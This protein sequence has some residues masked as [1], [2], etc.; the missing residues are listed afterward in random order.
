MRVGILDKLAGWKLPATKAAPSAEVGIRSPFVEGALTKVVVRDLYGLDT[1]PTTRAEAMSVPA[2]A[3]GRHLIVNDVSRCPLEV[4]APEDVELAP[5]AGAWLQSTRLQTSTQMRAVWTAD[6]H[7]FYGWSLW[8][9]SRA[10]DGTILDGARCP[11]EWWELDDNGTVLV[12][13]Q[14]VSSEQVILIPGYHEG[15]LSS[16][17]ETIR[18]GRRLEDLALDRI[19]NPVPAVELH[20]TSPVDLDPDEVRTLVADWKSAIRDEDGAVAYTPSSVEVKIHGEGSSDLLIQG[21]NAAAV[22]AAR[23]VGVPAAM[24]DA[25]NVNSSLTYETLQGRNLE[26]VDR[27]LSLYLGPVES[28]LSLDDVTPAGTRVRA[29]TSAIT[30][31]PP[32]PTGTDTKD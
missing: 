23:V 30:V 28:R 6:D 14:P 17:R 29:N 24:I 18:A 16:A 2:I 4:L 5:N 21:R 12:K 19:T 10:D 15:I 11:I 3:R 25:S 32:S 13:D 1:L 7:L 31:N 22:D 26:Y 9:V 27:S 8:V 20:N